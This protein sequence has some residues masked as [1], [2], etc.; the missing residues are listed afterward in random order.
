MWAATTKSE[1]Y[2]RIQ[3]M[4]QAVNEVEH[5]KEFVAG[6]LSEHMTQSETANRTA[7]KLH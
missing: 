2:V 3:G 5:R 7:A 1:E 6:N 4:K